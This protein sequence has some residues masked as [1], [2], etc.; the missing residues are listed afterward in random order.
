MLLNS[1]ILYK[2]KIDAN[3]YKNIFMTNQN[4]DLPV[5]AYP[6]SIKIEIKQGQKYKWCSCGLSTN[7]PFCDG[8]HAGSNFKPIEYIATEDRIVG[9]CGCKHSKIKP[10]CDGTHK[11]L[12]G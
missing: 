6:G 4:K 12:I 1:I 11:S 2:I 8:S 7:Q 9:F 3:N 10:I 5:I